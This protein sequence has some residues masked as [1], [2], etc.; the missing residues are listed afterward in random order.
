MKKLLILTCAALV[1]LTSL[2]LTSCS[3]EPDPDFGTV[4][5]KEHDP[6]STKRTC[7]RTNGKRRC[8]TKTSSEEWELKL[9]FDGTSFED[10]VSASQYEAAAEGDCW[11]TKADEVVDASK[12][13]A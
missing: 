2:G 11:S 8:T 4:T 9:S 12:C 7:K 10:E 13:A 3:S 5:G 6:A 1:A